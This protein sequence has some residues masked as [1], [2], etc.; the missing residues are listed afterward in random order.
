MNINNGATL[1]GGSSVTLTPAGIT[2]GKSSYVGPLHTRLEAE[3]VELFAST[4]L[5]NSKSPA[6]SRTGVKIRVTDVTA[7]AEGCCTTTVDEVIVDLGV[8]SSI[9]APD[10]LIDRV[11]AHLRG[12]VY[13]A[14]F[15]TALKKGILPQS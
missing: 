6:S 12:L 13:H 14:D 7:A 1:S 2:P 3:T 9:T 11:V 15:V 8:R 10:A 5:A 4:V